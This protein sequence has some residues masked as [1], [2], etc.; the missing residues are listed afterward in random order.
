MRKLLFCLSLMCGLAM[1]ALA[2]EEEESISPFLFEDY[3][4]AIVFFKNNAQ[5]KGKLN[6]YIP[7]GEYFFIDTADGNQIKSLGDL[8][9]INMIRFGKR[10]FLPSHKGGVEVLSADPLFYV[11]YKAVIRDQGRTV[12]FGG[13]S[14]LGSVKSYSSNSAGDAYVSDPLKFEVGHLYNIY[15][16]GK[17]QKEI[18]SMKQFLKFYSDHKEALEKYIDE[19]DIKFDNALQMMQLVQYAH[20]LT[21]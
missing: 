3:T 8:D 15:Y 11:Q 1:P 12:G 9:Q 18:S 19:N 2:Q 21:K 7:T 10:I 5:V 16:I 13:T 14:S 6:F 17:K 20:S 4:D